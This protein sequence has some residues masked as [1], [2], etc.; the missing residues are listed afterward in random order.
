[1]TR[2]RI[3]SILSFFCFIVFAAVQFNI[4]KNWDFDDG[5][6]VYRMVSN[7]I[8]G[9]GWTYNEGEAYNASTSVLNT[10]LIAIISSTRI[11][12]IPEAAHLL[13]AV[14]I[15][16]AAFFLY[17]SLRKFAGQIISFFAALFLIW[18]LSNNST[19]GLET[20]LFFALLMI[21]IYLEEEGKNSWPVLALIVL[22]R[23]DGMVLLGLK[24]LKDYYRKRDLSIRGI[25]Q[26]S[27]II[28][29]WIIFSI[30]RFQEIFPDTLASKMWQ[31]RSGYWGSGHIYYHA[32]KDHFTTNSSRL[33]LLGGILGIFTL[34]YQRSYFFYLVIFCL[35]QQAVYIFINVPGYHW[36]FSVLDAALSIL[37]IHFLATILVYLGRVLNFSSE[38]LK[39]RAAYLAAFLSVV[40]ILSHARHTPP[41]LDPRNEMYRSTIEWINSLNLKSGALA[42]LEVGTF[43]YHT[44]RKIVD[45]IGLASKNSEYISGAHNDEY[46]VEPAQLVVVHLPEWHFERGLLDDI[47]FKVSYDGP[48]KAPNG[49]M[50]YYS[51]KDP[52]E[53][54]SAEV[55][56]KY[57]RAHYIAAR[58]FT[59]LPSNL[60]NEKALCIVDQVNGKLLGNNTVSISKV[61]AR[62][63]GWAADQNRPKPEDVSVLLQNTRGEKYI[64]PGERTLREDVAL[65]LNNPEMKMSGFSAEASLLDL[66]PGDYSLQILQGSK[67]TS[68]ICSPAGILSVKDKL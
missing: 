8:N 61:T 20:N 26:F 18:Q 35:F 9:L 27:L 14:S 7:L 59:E 58:K 54:P 17:L 68:S 51:L 32:L 2:E 4:Y 40:F 28:S 53:K 1:M 43:G 56:E 67:E 49:E 66:P 39:L 36:Y 52:F 33:F 45:L 62:I 13:T 6:I 3:F 19:W 44:N 48:I 5:L 29:P 22:A 25:L 23:P 24:W 47:R 16:T 63:T 65:H 21:F 50:Q 34:I 30:L 55:V 10:L 12:T 15:C 41:I 38:S 11:F 31:G 57:I 37:T 46:F 64:I 42:T 60:N